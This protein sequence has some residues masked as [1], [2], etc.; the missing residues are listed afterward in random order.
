MFLASAAVA[1]VAVAAAIHFVTR[2]VAAEAEADLE[3]ALHEAG[4]LVERHYAARAET[5]ELVARLI[6]DLPKLKAAVET[7]DPPTVEPLLAEYRNKARADLLVVTNRRGEPLGLSGR[8]AAELPAAA[9]QAALRG[10]NAVT[11]PTTAEGALH[12]VSVPIEIGAAPPEVLGTLSLG[13]ALSEPLARE[14]KAVTQSDVAIAHQGRIVASTRSGAEAA[15][16]TPALS[17]EGIVTVRVGGGEYVAA[18]RRLG[19]GTQAETEAPVALILRSRTER[20]EF[21]GTFRAGLLLAAL[22]AV[23]VAVGLSY[24]VALTV[25][26]PLRA[27]TATMREMTDTGDLARKILLRRRWQDEDAAVLAATFNTLTDAIA[28]FQREAALRERLSALGRLSTVIAHEVRN[29]LMI[30]KG[31]LRA[32]RRG[33]PDPAAVQEALADIDHEA[34]RLN[35]IVTDVLDFARPVRLELAPADLNG[36]CREAAGAALDGEPG[37]RLQLSLDPSIPPARTDAERL[38]TVLVNVLVNA[39]EAVLARR[40]GPGGEASSG[41]SLEGGTA[42]VELRTRRL[43]SGRVEL[44]VADSGDGIDP[45]ALAHV[46]EPYFTTKRTGT[47]LGLAIAKNIVDALGGSLSAASVP[48][49]GTEIRIELPLD[50]EPALPAAA[51]ASG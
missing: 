15:Q 5:L 49:R 4:T 35:R 11:F 46:F 26:R 40:G 17:G 6:A 9:V 22:V 38:R 3:R 28:R 44:T 23:V 8:P 33:E 1:V 47:G 50:R 41:R 16:L 2:R 24:A 12:V 13:F 20:L 39:R 37:L 21:L 19:G 30:I 14:L 25:T 32:L 27:I 31:A 7:G 18:H 34:A 51:G 48:G 42:E 29:P 45:A 10:G 36:V 43:P